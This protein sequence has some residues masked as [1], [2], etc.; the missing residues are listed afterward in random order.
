MHQ[1]EHS[2]VYS[3]SIITDNTYDHP[4]PKPV[5][6]LRRYVEILDAQRV[7]DPFAGSGT[8]IVACEQL[9]RACY[10]MEVEPRYVDM[11]IARWEQYTG[12]KAELQE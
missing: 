6:L 4:T 10:A 8:T 7:L 2:K 12:G 9:G 1:S 5:P 11:A 3:S